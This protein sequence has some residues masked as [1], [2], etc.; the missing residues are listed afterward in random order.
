MIKDNYLSKR[1]VMYSRHSAE[2]KQEFSIPLQEEEGKKFADKFN[3]K[4]IKFFRDAGKSGLKAEN[5]PDFLKLY[6]YAKT[7]KFDYVLVF[8]ATRWGRFQDTDEAAYYEMLFKREGKRIIYIE[9]GFIEDENPLLASLTKSID[10]YM[11][12]DYSRKLSEKVSLGSKKIASLGFSVGGKA[13]YGLKR[14]LLNSHKQPVRIL[15]D[16][17]RKSIDNERVTFTPGDKK[18]IEII[19]RIFHQFTEEKL[20]KKEIAQLLNKEGIKSPKGKLWDTG[21]VH[22][23]LNNEN[24]IGTKI[25]NKR[26]QKLKTPSR[27]NPRDEWIKVENAFEAI[28]LKELFFRV[29]EKL[30]QLKV[31]YTQEE[32]ISELKKIYREYKRI[33]S[34]LIN[35][36][37]ESKNTAC[38]STYT[39]RFVSLYN[40]Y[41]KVEYMPKR[42][43]NFFK[44]R[45]KQR[46]ILVGHVKEKLNVN[47]YNV[48]YKDEFLYINNKKINIIP[49]IPR[50]RHGYKYWTFYFET[51]KVDYVLC[52]GFEDKD[53]KDIHKYYLF[54]K[55]MI[56]ENIVNINVSRD[57]KYDDYIIEDLNEISHL[58]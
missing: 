47:G 27:K 33:T 54:P 35:E 21:K 2:D 58:N 46:L 43:F 20:L 31:H 18:E 23:I 29:Q 5:R 11:A 44:K 15:N 24:Y 45:E 8:D 12:A 16:G 56:K 22:D 52:I 48:S 40:A 38:A 49:S 10:R 55:E 39:R 42:A 53:A 41:I 6:E 26:T 32:L 7:H 3:I 14:M 37:K 4:I 9:R 57:S 13:P 30:G 28:I 36:W 19:K 17:E 50:K 51:Q 34:L 25:Y 1:A